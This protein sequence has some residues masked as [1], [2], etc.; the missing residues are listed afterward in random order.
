MLR[1]PCSPRARCA[2]GVAQRCCAAGF[3]FARVLRKL[4]GR[5]GAY[6]REM[7]AAGR[8][9]A[10]SVDSLSIPKLLI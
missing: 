2:R 5:A 4:G 3:W 8:L 7:D 1:R 9:S 10:H 6:S